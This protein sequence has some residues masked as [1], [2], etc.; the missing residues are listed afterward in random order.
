MVNQDW[1]YDHESKIPIYRKLLQY[2]ENNPYPDLVK[3][4]YNPEIHNQ[5]NESNLEELKNY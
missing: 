2:V 3:C 4:Y 5:S 1:I